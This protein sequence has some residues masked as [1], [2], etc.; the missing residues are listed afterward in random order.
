MTPGE[1]LV[2]GKDVPRARVYTTTA[3]ARICGVS[4]RMVCTWCDDGLLA[5][6]RP[7]GRGAKYRHRRITHAALAA[8]MAEQKIPLELLEGATC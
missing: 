4:D 2:T 3:A 5:S 7:P 8:F 1:E 6:Y